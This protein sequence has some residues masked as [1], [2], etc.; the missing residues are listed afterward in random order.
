MKKYKKKLT[1]KACP[2]KLQRS[3]GFTMIELVVVIAIVALISSLIIF[4][5]SSFNSASSLE[6][7]S[8]DIALTIRKAQVSAIGVKGVTVGLATEFPPFGVSFSLVPSN[9]S[10]LM[11]DEKSFIYFA[12]LGA[13]GDKQYN[14]GSG[15]ACG[16]LSVGNECMDIVKI[17]TQ[18]VISEICADSVCYNKGD[19]PKVDIVFTRPYPEASFKFYKGSSKVSVSSVGIRLKSLDNKIKTITVWNTGQISVQ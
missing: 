5:Y 4:N 8:Q 18:E 6:N 14:P 1:M 3:R 7:V 15:D 2:A 16:N 11:G 13:T 12:D 17:K 19:S 10:N 9:T